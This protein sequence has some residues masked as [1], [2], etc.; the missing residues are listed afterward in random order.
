MK[1]LK[2]ITIILIISG[3]LFVSAAVLLQ[4]FTPLGGFH[5]KTVRDTKY[6]ENVRELVVISGSI[7]VELGY[8]DGELCEVS[9]VTDL[10]LIITHEE[11]GEL[12]VTQDDSFTL[13]LFARD[14][15]NYKISVKI[16]R[17]SYGRIS[18]SGSGGDITV[19]DNISCE[20]LEISTKTGDINLNSADERT[21]IK[22]TNGNISLFLS[23]LNGDM[24][25]NGGAGDITVTT[26]KELPFFMEFSTENGSCTVTGFENEI[27]GRKGDASF[28]NG[29][30]GRYLKINTQ[31]G[32]LSITAKEKDSK[33]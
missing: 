26:R 31:N 11:T 25:I 4:L 32:N 6:Y 15:K 22:T 2:T 7:P 3:V 17:K 27:T 14:K 1:K 33:K 28:L 30:G 20:T 23:A 13:S 12:R 16:P 9:G 21:K 5:N 10:P 8:T 24:T 18:L 29:K 19:Y